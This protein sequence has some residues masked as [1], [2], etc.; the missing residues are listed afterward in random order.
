MGTTL[1]GDS[2]VERGRKLCVCGESHLHSPQAS[3]SL[4][5]NHCREG[6][7]LPQRALST[8]RESSVGTTLWGDSEVERGGKLCVCGESQLHSPQASVSLAGTHCREGRSLPLGALST[9]EGRVGIAEVG[10]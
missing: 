2:E 10:L 1:W 6:H 9:S 3:V 8:Q 7:S 5:V 4:A